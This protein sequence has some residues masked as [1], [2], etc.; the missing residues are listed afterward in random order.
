MSIIDFDKLPDTTRLWIYASERAFS[1]S[2]QNLIETEMSQFLENWTA[3]KR[4]LKTG[5][6]LA[7]RQFVLVAVD[8]SMMAASGCSIDSIVKYLAQLQNRLQCKIVGTHANIFF[9][10][11]AGAVQCVDRPQFKQ[12]LSEDK[13]NSETIVFDNTI[14]TLGDFRLGKWEVAMKNSW[15]GQAFLEVV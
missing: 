8:E 2:E 11:Q 15:H 6:Q 7:H 14:Q 5:W 12:L 13:V 10:D 1:D 9:K 4:E 3:H